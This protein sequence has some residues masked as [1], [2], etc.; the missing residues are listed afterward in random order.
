MKIKL[1]IDC[2]PEE[3][4]SF[5][6]LPDVAPLQAAVMKEAQDRMMAALKTMD[7]EGMFKT[8]MPSGVEGFEKMQRAFWE[9]LA[10]GKKSG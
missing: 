2:T 5:F 1:D 8:W 3:A 10:G 9:G 4:R 6:G 7:A